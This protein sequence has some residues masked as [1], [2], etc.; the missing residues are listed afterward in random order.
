M[1]RTIKKDVNI[2][3]GSDL[4]DNIDINNLGQEFIDDNDIEN[5]NNNIQ[6]NN[7]DNIIAFQN[8]IMNALGGDMDLLIQNLDNLNNLNL[9]PLHSSTIFQ[10]N[11]EGIKSHFLNLLN[12]NDKYFVVLSSKKIKKINNPLKTYFYVS[13]FDFE[14]ME[15]IS[16]IELDMF[17]LEENR[18]IW[19]D[20]I[21]ENEKKLNVIINISQ[22]NGPVDEKK[23]FFILNKGE[24]IEAN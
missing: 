17:E 16:K 7:I 20:L 1:N 23:Y 5:D 8:N 4:I 18:N 19:V 22:N 9:P 21:N 11:E 10:V 2:C 14:T 3:S 6:N 12:M 24:L 13:L 15:E